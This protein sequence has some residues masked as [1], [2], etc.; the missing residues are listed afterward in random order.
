M[1]EV[2][3]KVSVSVFYICC[4]YFK[5]SLNTEKVCKTVIVKVYR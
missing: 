5:D 4:R 3:K 1:T 2:S